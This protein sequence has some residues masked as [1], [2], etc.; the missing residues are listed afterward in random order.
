[1][2]LEAILLVLL[3]VHG[4][5]ARRL[6]RTTVTGPLAFAAAGMAVELAAPSVTAAATRELFR[7]LAEV[8]LVLVLYTDASRTNLAVLA[9]IRAL[10]ARLL[11][12]G[13]LLTIAAG[14]LT[15]RLVFPELGLA[16]AGILAAILAP[17]DA[18]LGQVVVTSPRVPLRIREALNVEAGLNDGLCVPFLLFFMALAAAGTSGA[19]S[20]FLQ[21][22]AEQLGLGLVVGAGIGLAGGWLLGVAHRA[23]WSGG[24]SERIASI[25]LS[26]LA[27]L[28]SEAVGASAFIAAFVAGL[29]VQLGFPR[30][31]EHSVEFA[32]EWGLVLAL[33][34]FFLFG[35][36]VVRNAGAWNV[37]VAAYAVLSLTVV[38]ML[39]V[40]LAVAGTGLSRASVLFLGWFGPRGL[41]SIVLGLVYLDEE[42]RLPGESLIHAAVVA[43]VAASIAAH[44]LTAAPGIRRYARNLGSLPDGAPERIE[45]A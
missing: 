15:A 12:A 35:A 9:S 36:V 17:T 33:A 25:A 28:A 24:K 42:L 16:E 21:F 32:D 23:R 26:L 31:G 45:Q 39:P 40:A 18:G 7:R 11:S 10:P 29:A 27:L 43:T 20:S 19:G 4:I 30:A 34:V 1:M 3:F 22:V 6:A 37:R 13:L 14:A 5:T 44:G 41:A 38:R 2:L 8:A